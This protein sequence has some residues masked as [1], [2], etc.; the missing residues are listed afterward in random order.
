MNQNR[1]HTPYYFH[2][3]AFRMYSTVGMFTLFHNNDIPLQVYGTIFK[4]QLDL[5]LFD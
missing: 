2:L 5:L 4:R 3:N 1:V